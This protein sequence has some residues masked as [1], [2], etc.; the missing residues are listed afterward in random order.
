MVDGPDEFRSV[1]ADRA[2]MVPEKCR[3]DEQAV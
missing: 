2:R 1:A 3:F